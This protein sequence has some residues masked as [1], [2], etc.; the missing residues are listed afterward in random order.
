[1][2]PGID[3]G[4]AA[5]LQIQNIA[6][7]ILAVAASMKVRASGRVSRFPLECRVRNRNSKLGFGGATFRP[8]LN[9]SVHYYLVTEKKG[10]T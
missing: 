3:Q 5:A 7:C 6:G 9:A 8:V 10:Q 4:Y 1:M 2:S